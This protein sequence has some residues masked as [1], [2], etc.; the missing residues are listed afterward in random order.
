MK[1]NILETLTGAIV[2]AGAGC[3]FYYAYVS[4]GSQPHHGYHLYA[5]F[6]RIDGLLEGNDV[7]LSGVKVG[8]VSQITLDPQSYLAVVEISL[9]STIQLSTDTSAQIASE[10]LMG[11]KY[12]ALVPG[13]D[14]GKPLAPNDIIT[15][16]QSS[17]N[18]EDLIG[19]Y[20]FTKQDE[21]TKAS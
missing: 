20:L 19:K 15:A 7:K 11:G 8:E 13:A 3:F 6:D 4:S 14:D 17:I 9:D 10:G 2:L 5:K 12:V 1:S 21:G 18:F 16:T